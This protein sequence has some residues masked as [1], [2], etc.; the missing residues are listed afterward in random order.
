MSQIAVI[1]PVYN[2]EKTLARCVD[3]VLGQTMADLSLI[4]VDDGS[5]DRSPALC[6][7][8][9]KADPRVTVIHQENGGLSAARNAGIEAQLPLDNRYLFLLDSDDSIE[10]TALEE[11][12]STAL[13]T[14]ADITVCLFRHILYDGSIEEIPAEDLSLLREETLTGRDFL[15]R[16]LYGG[17]YCT[18]ICVVV[19]NKL[20][21]KE[22]FDAL[23]FDGRIAEDEKIC[24]SLFSFD[25]KVALLPRFLHNY[26][27]TKGSLMTK[28]LSPA[29][30]SMLDTLLQ[31][32]NDFATSPSLLRDTK[33]LFCDLVTEYYCTPSMKGQEALF[34]PYLAPFR[35]LRKELS[36]DKKTK[37]RFLLFSFS[38]RLYRLLLQLRHS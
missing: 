19:W 10:P 25:R 11:L 37:L 4:L 7:A 17:T 2:A 12:L 35:R 15:E 8:Y 16:F 14:E 20:Y 21:R 3:S 29:H 27:E 24:S 5:T 31:R 18:P 32:L 33:K 30:L 9:A 22:I 34:T 38:P 26:Y 6:D 1:V 23:R 28:P 36:L 13:E